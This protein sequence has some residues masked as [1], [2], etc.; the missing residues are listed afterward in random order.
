MLKRYLFLI[1]IICLFTIST[2]SAED[3]ATN[4][5]I[6]KYNN[7]N[8]L[9]ANSVGYNTNSNANGNDT[10][11]EVNNELLT[12]G[13]NWYVN[14][15]V[16][17][18]GNGSKEFPFKTLKEAIN[19]AS[20]NDA[21]MIASGEYK[22]KD[23][24]NLEINKNLN[25]MKLDD[26]K[27]IF[28][29]QGSSR[30]WTVTATSINITGLI[31]INGK[32]HLGNDIDKF[33]GAIY[34]NNIL[35]N[36]NINATFINN[37]AERDGGAIYFKYVVN[38][39]YTNFHGNLTG[40]FFNNKANN[41]GGAIA[42]NGIIGNLN[43]IFINNNAIGG[44]GAIY[45][46]KHDIAGNLTGWFINNQAKDGGAIYFTK[47]NTPIGNLNA[48]FINNTAISEG[49][50][51]YIQNGTIF[52]NLTS[53]F[54]NNAAKDGGAIYIK[55]GRLFDKLTSTFVRNTAKGGNGG[56]IYIQ[57]GTISDNLT[58]IFL[59]NTAKDGGAIYIHNITNLSVIHDCIFINNDNT[60]ICAKSGNITT[61]NCWF[62][63]NATNY[64]DKPEVGN[65]IIDNWLFLNATANTTKLNVGETSTINFKLDSYNDTSKKIS[66]YNSSMNIIL[67]LTQT[68]GELN[69]NNASINENISYTARETGNANV[70][71]K[72]EN[73]YYT[74]NIKNDENSDSK[75]NLTINATSN[76]IAVGEDATIN[77]TGLEDATGNVTVTIDN[78]NYTA[79]IKDGNASVNV[80]DLSA[81]NFTAYVFYA[82]ILHLL[83]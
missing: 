30:I 49:G 57:N 47:Q 61:I 39:T 13:N 40:A 23:N 10:L 80:S 66:Q 26:G 12:T 46:N 55:N 79:T 78:R 69:K 29:A 43:A 3:N 18:T 67:D 48:V 11:K 5:I 77:I 71:G 21:I 41:R 56:A 20:D 76:P 35:T 19:N 9:E 38:G 51:I 83:V 82:V 22:G 24:I 27:V 54:L 58:S 8:N 42:F 36:S 45:F 59:N 7:V 64:N 53:T 17:T 62:G 44:G 63:N 6:S 33:G 37:T 32:A 16:D 60:T 50:A 15:S 74:V 70:T 52:G 65:V 31:F 25:F 1:I 2:V 81:G 34:F 72:F 75:K 68:L 4:E 73:A 28:D 14:G